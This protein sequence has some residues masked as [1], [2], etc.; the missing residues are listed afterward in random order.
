MNHLQINKDH[1]LYY[2]KSY[3]STEEFLILLKKNNI[4]EAIF[5]PPCT[6]YKEPEKSRFM[7]AL[8][9]KLLSNYIGFKISKKISNSFYNSD[10][11]LRL[12]WKI[13]SGNKDLIKVNYPENEKLYHEIKK[14]PNLQMWYWLNPIHKNKNF[15]KNF[16]EMNKKIYGFK[17]HQYWH[18]FKLSETF[19]YSDFIK[20][21]NKPI[22][23]ILGY[24]ILDNIIEFIKYN[25]NIK[26]IFGYGGFPIFQNIWSI[27]NKYDNCYIDVASNHIDSKIIRK[28]YNDVDK[29]KIIFSSDCPYNFKNNKNDFDYNLFK[30]NFKLLKRNEKEKLFSNL[31]S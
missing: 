22:Y 19:K 6:K 4:K 21:L 29:T 25:K 7:Y 12:F 26:I 18:N 28:I 16:I 1:H 20:K 24:E 13:F 30:K 9:R 15:E 3:Y 5:S 23:L 11:E 14:F 2:D 27:I 8:Q 17:F 31:I 10:N